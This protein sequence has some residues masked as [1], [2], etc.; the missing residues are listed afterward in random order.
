[1]RGTRR[2]DE[3]GMCGGERAGKKEGK[4]NGVKDGNGG[5]GLQHGKKLPSFIV[6]VSYQSVTA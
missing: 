1:M 2:V 3:G 6:A 5:Y 4:G